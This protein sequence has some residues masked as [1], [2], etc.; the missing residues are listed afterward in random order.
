MLRL[1]LLKIPI[2]TVAPP[3]RHLL[4]GSLQ[5]L[6][7]TTLLQ[8]WECCGLRAS[9]GWKTKFLFTYPKSRHTYDPLG[10]FFFLFFLSDG[11]R[12]GTNEFSL[13]CVTTAPPL[14]AASPLAPALS[15]P[16]CR[17]PRLPKLT[18]NTSPE[19]GN[20]FD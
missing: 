7:L 15:P 10:S 2:L 9:E 17:A 3:G 4:S 5:E 20:S 6:R 11:E 19:K 13:T 12:R 18:S 1:Q 8:L 14:Y 16:S